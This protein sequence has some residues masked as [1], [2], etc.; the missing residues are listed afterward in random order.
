MASTIISRLKK[1]GQ[2]VIVVDVVGNSATGVISW[3]DDDLFALR[4]EEGDEVCFGLESF[5]SL[6]IPGGIEQ[7]HAGLENT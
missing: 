4:T 1:T 3:W 5:A 7:H 2:Q 6:T